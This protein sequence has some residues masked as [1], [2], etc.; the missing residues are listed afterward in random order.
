MGG[1]RQCLGK[2]PDAERAKP[3]RLWA[4]CFLPAAEQNLLTAEH[5]KPMLPQSL[6]FRPMPGTICPR[7]H[8]FRALEGGFLA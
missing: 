8:G 6:V 5:A 3:M 1:A 7:P 4:D 2:K